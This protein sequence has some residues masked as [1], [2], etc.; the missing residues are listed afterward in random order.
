MDADT[1]LT[2]L[3]VLAT[4]LSAAWASF[5]GTEIYQQ[6]VT[7]WRSLV[8]T[9]AVAAVRSVYFKQVNELKKNNGKLTPV[10]AEQARA[11]ARAVLRDA[12]KGM[13]PIRIPAVL[14]PYMTNDVLADSIIETAVNISKKESALEITPEYV[15][16]WFKRFAKP[17]D[18]GRG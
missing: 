1:I 10:E 6:R 4:A 2:L 8:V 3:S 14:Q 9:L 17:L 16:G 12:I 18:M 15:R 11:D 5:K 13:C 7:G